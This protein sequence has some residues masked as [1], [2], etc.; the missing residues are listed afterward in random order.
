MLLE[1]RGQGLAVAAGVGARPDHR[2]GAKHVDNAGLRARQGDRDQA[3][4]AW[5]TTSTQSIFKGEIVALEPEFTKGG[6]VIAIRAYDKSHR[7]QRVAQGADVPGRRGDRHRQDGS[8][9][10]ARPHR[11]ARTR[12]S[13]TL[14]VLPAERRDRPRADRQLERDYDFRFFVDERQLQVPPTPA[15]V[16]GATVD[17]RV[18]RGSLL[19]LPARASSGVQQV[20]QVEVRG[21]DPASK[22]AINGDARPTASTTTKP[23]VQRIDGGDGLRRRHKVLVADR[24]VETRGEA[25]ED[26][27]ERRSTAAPTRYVEAEGALPRQ[28]EAPGRHEGQDQGRRHASFG[29]DVRRHLGDRTA[30]AAR[31]ATT[32]SFD[33][34]RALRRAAC[35][36]SCTRPRS[37]TGAAHLVVGARDQRERPRQARAREGQ[38]PDAARRQD[39]QLGE[40]LGAHRH[41]RGRATTA[42]C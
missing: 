30:T 7:L 5:P 42:A 32:T 22:K 26:G 25:N 18:R 37:A 28:P 11:R 1:V 17:A 33:D 35:S 27:Q 15:S 20:K 13:A 29:G 40:H 12:R 16:G 36:T 34:H 2:P 3:S 21:W 24:V 4:A 6:C 10:E 14:Q 8:R 23:G 38:V 9:G 39:S 31:R 19:E 41:A